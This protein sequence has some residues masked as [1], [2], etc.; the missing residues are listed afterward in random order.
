MGELMK[1]IISIVGSVIVFVIASFAFK[2]EEL[3]SF[4]KGI[5]RN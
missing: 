2:V 3:R 5:L 4:I 1:V